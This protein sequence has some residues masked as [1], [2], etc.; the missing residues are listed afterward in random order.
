MNVS[1]SKELQMLTKGGN[2]QYILGVNEPEGHLTSQSGDYH[3][4]SGSAAINAGIDAGVRTDLDGHPR[5]IGSGFDIGAYEFGTVY[6]TYLP[7]A[8]KHF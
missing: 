1:G 3:I 8:L 5:P 6:K 7:L 2:S 4:G